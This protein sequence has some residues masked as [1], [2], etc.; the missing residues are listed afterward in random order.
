MLLQELLSSRPFHNHHKIHLISIFQKRVHIK[1]MKLTNYIKTCCFQIYWY[2]SG[3]IF[4]ACGTNTR[5]YCPLVPESPT[6]RLGPEEI[7]ICQRFTPRIVTQH[8]LKKLWIR[9]D[10][11]FPKPDMAH[12]AQQHT[13]IILE[14]QKLRLEDHGF[15][16]SVSSYCLLLW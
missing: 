7:R 10:L 13:P 3:G 16:T 1:T 8:R 11:S 14:L 12:Q 4:R 6:L 15:K 5:N 9:Q 2:L